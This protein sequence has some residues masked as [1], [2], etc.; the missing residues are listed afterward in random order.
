MNPNRMKILGAF[1]GLFTIA[2]YYKKSKISRDIPQPPRSFLG[3]IGKFTTK[4]LIRYLEYW[5]ME[6]GPIFRLDLIIQE[7]V[8]ISDPS[9]IIKLLK[10]RPEGVS[11]DN[12]IEPQFKRLGLH[13]MFSEEGLEWKSSRWIGANSFTA[14][15]INGMKSIIRKHVHNLKLDLMEFANEQQDLYDSF[16]TSSNGVYSV[17]YKPRK[18]ME[19]VPKLQKMSMGIILETFG[20]KENNLLSGQFSHDFALFMD[21]IFDQSIRVFPIHYFYTSNRAKILG[22]V[23]KQLEKLVNSTIDEFYKVREKKSPENPFVGSVLESMILTMERDSGRNDKIKRVNI[24]KIV[25]NFIQFI[26]AGTDTTAVTLNFTLLHLAQNPHVQKR[27]QLEADKVLGVNPTLEDLMAVELNDLP[28]CQNVI[29]ETLRVSP[30]AL[31]LFLT[32]KR[33]LEILNYNIPKDTDIIVLLRSH[34]FRNCATSEPFE[35]KPERWEN[36]NEQQLKEE[37]VYLLPFGSGPRICPGRTLAM[38]DLTL[39]LAYA[40]SA[41]DIS[42]FPR[43]FGSPAPNEYTSFT[44]T[45]GNFYPRFIPRRKD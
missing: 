20:V 40:V 4:G 31:S 7:Y 8:V 43:P 38:N 24:D 21:E 25:G 1:I 32:N 44:N 5:A 17:N 14:S 16:F 22:K 3:H 18:L 19:I 28:Y 34:N 6:L 39:A 30:P 37:L 26:I 42:M 15:K 33:D 41:F 12:S 23:Q 9:V 29:R 27:V 10:D 35:F 36:L 13:G 45:L 11:R 2:I